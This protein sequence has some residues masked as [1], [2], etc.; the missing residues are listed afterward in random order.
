[1]STH[2]TNPIPRAIRELGV[3]LW[4]GSSGASARGPMLASAND[5]ERLSGAF[6]GLRAA[7]RLTHGKGG[8]R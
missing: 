6:V 2:N 1:M 5:A 4:L 7:M 8:Y 3:E